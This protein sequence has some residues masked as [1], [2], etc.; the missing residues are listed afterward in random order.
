MSMPK[1]AVRG[2]VHAVD[3]EQPPVV[4]NTSGHRYCA[5]L[6]SWWAVCSGLRRL[7]RAST[8]DLWA[9]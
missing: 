2:A 5:A 4:E 1:G 3:Q 8:P 6:I 7:T 9:R